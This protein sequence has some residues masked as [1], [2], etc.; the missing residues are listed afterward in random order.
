MTEISNT[1]KGGVYTPPLLFH[2]DQDFNRLQSAQIHFLS[3]LLIA[4]GRFI[5]ILYYIIQKKMLSLQW[6]IML[7]FPPWYSYN[8]LMLSDYYASRENFFL[9]V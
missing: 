3:R 9:S 4:E 5:F 8:L 7:N 1:T 2:S 6:W